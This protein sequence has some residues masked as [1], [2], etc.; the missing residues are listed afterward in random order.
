MF[1]IEGVKIEGV[2]VAKKIIHYYF[3][4]NTPRPIS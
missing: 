1:I 3:L 4:N 2:A